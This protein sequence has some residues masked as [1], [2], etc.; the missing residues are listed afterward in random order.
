MVQS[1]LLCG[2]LSVVLLRFAGNGSY[3]LNGCTLDKQKWSGIARVV[4]QHLLNKLNLM[5]AFLQAKQ[6][7]IPLHFQH[8]HVVQNVEWNG[9]GNGIGMGTN[10]S[11][12]SYR[13]RIKAQL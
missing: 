7:P 10:L 6:I 3:P 8:V 2:Q 4:V 1:C 13:T 9:N 5:S 12:A 11:L